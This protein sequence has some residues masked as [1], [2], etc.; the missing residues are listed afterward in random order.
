MSL[1]TIS[2]IVVASICFANSVRTFFAC[3]RVL[4]QAK[5]VKRQFAEMVERDKAA[6]MEVKRRLDNLAALVEAFEQQAKT[7]SN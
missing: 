5:E 4:R 3:N 1:F 7:E 2:L 6:R